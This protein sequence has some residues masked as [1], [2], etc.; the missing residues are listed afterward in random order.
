MAWREGTVEG[1]AAPMLGWRLWRLHEG[2]LR[3][4]AVSYD[5]SPGRNLARC[6]GPGVSRCQDSPGP[7]CH[8]GF[9]GLYDPVD[10]LM[11]GRYQGLGWWPV[12][13]L[14]RGWG[15]GLSLTAGGGRLPLHRLALS[16]EAGPA[17][18]EPPVALATR[19]GAARGR[20]RRSAPL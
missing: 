1:D 7:G 18:S 15:G 6:I 5:W 2:A 19:P 10:C 14:M 17:D 4:W 3:S 9:W 11:R 12:V 20:G 13:G 16:A 8:C